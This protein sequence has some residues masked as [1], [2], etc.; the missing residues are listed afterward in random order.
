MKGYSNGMNRLM[1][2]LWG[3]LDGENSNSINYQIA[4]VLMDNITSI[5]HTSSSSLAELCNVSKP[6]ISRFVKDLGYDDYYD[7][8]AEINHY[9]PDRGAKFFD[10]ENEDA[11]NYAD[12]YLDNVVLKVEIMKR[13]EVQEQIIKLADDI[14]RYKYVYLMG[15]MQSGTTASNLHYNLHVIKK[16]IQAITSLS[17]RKEVLENLKADSLVVIFSVSGEYYHAFYTENSIPVPPPKTKV[18]MV[19]TNPALHNIA[20]V[21]ELINCKTGNSLAGGNICLELIA[22]QLAMYCWKN[23]TVK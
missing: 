15:N 18:W 2:R 17:E 9:Y 14:M 7:F 3:I 13:N 6:S 1:I 5:E 16:N 10:C 11:D 19:T 23:H 20:G 21:D 4:K 12:K 8:R 22:N